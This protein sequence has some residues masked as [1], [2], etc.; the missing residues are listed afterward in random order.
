MIITYGWRV[1]SV[2]FIGVTTPE[3]IYELQAALY[4]MIHV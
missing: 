1:L 2:G 3:N 4:P